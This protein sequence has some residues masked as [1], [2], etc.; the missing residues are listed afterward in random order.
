MNSRRWHEV[1]INEASFCSYLFFLFRQPIWLP[2]IYSKADLY[3]FREQMKLTRKSLNV[4][5][6]INFDPS[7]QDICLKLLTVK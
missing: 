7:V 6:S 5:P 2:I 4:P 3:F 1:I